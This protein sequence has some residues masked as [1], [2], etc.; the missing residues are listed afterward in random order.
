MFVAPQLE[1]SLRAKSDFGREDGKERVAQETTQ[2]VKCAI[3]TSSE[4]V[5][6]PITFRVPLLLVQ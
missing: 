3:F 4:A 5:E 2:E 6:G 1:I